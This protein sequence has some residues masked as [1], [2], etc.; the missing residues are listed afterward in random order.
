M[1]SSESPVTR[2]RAHTDLQASLL[3][4][5]WLVDQVS[6]FQLYLSPEL[7]EKLSNRINP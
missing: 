2:E 6:T 5:F 7:V 4:A 3:A 1:R